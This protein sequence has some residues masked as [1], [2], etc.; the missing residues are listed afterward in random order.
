[1]AQKPLL[2][3]EMG[4]VLVCLGDVDCAS[5]LLLDIIRINP[6]YDL[7]LWSVAHVFDHSTSTAKKF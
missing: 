1:M 6:T 2:W 7:S 4:K 5:L 3:V